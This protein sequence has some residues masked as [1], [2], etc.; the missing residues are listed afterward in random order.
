MSIAIPNLDDRTFDELV[1][2]GL[3]LLPAYAPDWTNHNPSDPGI[4]LVELLAY[5]TEMLIYRLGRVTPQSKLQFLRLLEGAEW[6]AGTGIDATDELQRAID[7]AV[8]DMAHMD[9]AVTAQDF[10]RFALACLGERLGPGQPVRVLCV[11]SM[12]LSDPAASAAG[13]SDPP[14]VSVVVVP[15]SER[16]D[17]QTS[18]ID[19][20]KT[21]L[22]PRCLLG[23]RLHV[24]RPVY[25]HVAIGC[26]LVP[27]PGHSMQALAEEVGD[28]LRRAFGSQLGEGPQGEG[29]PFGRSLHMSDLFE[30]IDAMPGVDYVEHL[31]VLQID[32]RGDTVDT[33]EASVGIQIGTRST[34]GVDT[35]LGGPSRL[36]A[37]RLLRDDSGK[38]M[39][40]VLRPWELLRVS[41]A[42]DGLGEVVRR[43]VP[44]ETRQSWR[45]GR[46]G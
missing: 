8:R 40:I 19:D 34:V 1:R 44:Q 12:D 21:D 10:E 16:P 24:V 31:S 6:Q 33:A 36:G 25:L 26:K 35:R 11:P 46:H 32:T 13:R 41:V 28:E 38:L 30:A 14:H 27:K 2:E 20:V 42:R 37:G 22:Q 39:A 17:V 29:W 18:L 45:G 5:F 9:C 43:T 3:S 15:A 23:T 7:S 4:T